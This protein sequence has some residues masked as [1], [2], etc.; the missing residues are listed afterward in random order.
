MSRQCSR[1]IVQLEDRPRLHRVQREFLCVCAL[2]LPIMKVPAEQP[3]RDDAICRLRWLGERKLPVRGLVALPCHK[4][5]SSDCRCQAAC[6]Q[7]RASGLFLA[8]NGNSALA[9]VIAIGFYLKF[10]FQPFGAPRVVNQCGAKADEAAR[11]RSPD[12]WIDNAI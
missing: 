5:R 12:A 10:N 7:P 4:V 11:V 2:A 1:R 9:V 8:S 3:L 6:K